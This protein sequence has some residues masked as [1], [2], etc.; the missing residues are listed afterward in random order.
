VHFQW[1]VVPLLDAL[2]IAFIRRRCP[3]VI[4]VHDT[5]AFNGERPS[6]LQ[7]FAA[8]L[9]LRLADRLIVH[10][11]AGERTLLR[12][13]VPAEKLT[14]IPHGPLAL[15]VVASPWLEGRNDSRRTFV[16]FGEL[17]RYKGIDVLVEALGLLPRS[18]RAQARFV[19]AGRPRMDLTPLLA[20]IAALDLD[21][22]VE[23]RPRRLC[24]QE[25]A[26]L[27]ASADCFLF[28]YR[29]ID[30]SGVYFLVKSYRRWI[31]ASRVGIFAEELADGER[32]ALVAAE[33]PAALAVAVA[34]AIVERHEPSVALQDA[35]WAEIGAATRALYLRATGGRGAA[36]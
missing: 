25:M 35:T 29:Q 16:L 4:T 34:A 6:N 23:L 36:R 12:R 19:V 10:T 24:E 17:K 15:D 2:A 5:V 14:V 9:P 11:R 20:R 22:C 7:V 27:F 30:A 8:D 18:L 21:G 28:P 3:I 13:R 31:I 33:D 32:G 1:L 26:D